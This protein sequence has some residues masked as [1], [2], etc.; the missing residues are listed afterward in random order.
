MEQL[1]DLRIQVQNDQEA[2]IG[3]Q[4][5]LGVIGFD[6]KDSMYLAANQIGE[7]TKSSNEATINRIVAE[8]KYRFLSDSDLNLIETQS[9]MLAS[10]KTSSTAQNSLLEG[11]RSSRAQ[12]ASVYAS[13]STQYGPNY[14]DVKQAKA[15][16]DGIDKEIDTEEKRVLSQARMSFVA[17][18][19]AEKS[20]TAAL[21]RQEGD[22]FKSTSDL[23][24]FAML[25]HDYEAHRTLYEGLV[26]RLREAGITSGLESGEVDVVDL[27]DLP[28][29]PSPP[30]P[31]TFIAG[32]IIIGF[33][34]G[35]L[36]ALVVDAL[37]TSINNAAQVEAILR[38]PLL[39]LLP[40]LD[41]VHL[42]ERTWDF[43]YAEAIQSLRSSVLLARA[44]SPPKVIMITSA[45]P[46]EG[47]SF[48]ARNLA[49][50][51]AQHDARILLIDCD[52]RRG[53]VAK[54]LGIS[55]I[56]GLSSLL[57]GQSTLE[58]AVQSVP[59]IPNLSV[60]TTGPHPPLPSVLIGSEAMNRLISKCREEY[61]FIILDSPPLLAITDTMNMVHLADVIVLVAR[62]NISHKQA[63]TEAHARLEIANADVLGFVLND[64]DPKWGGYN[65]VYHDYYGDETKAKGE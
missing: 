36:V 53:T 47:K 10:T 7:L 38:R 6:T 30:G 51:F 59:G 17:A 40:R 12:A 21:N 55:A 48:T 49:K 32:G 35:S 1:N 4:Q 43:R 11:L 58:R 25:S 39:G 54:S 5:R 56:A 50:A 64:V 29:I 16:L 34:V 19:A 37:E 26:G 23:A 31:I 9:P 14:P 63:I 3:L 13:L 20:T 42:A 24:K 65:Y 15:Q 62:Q 44:D 57:T 2:L 28:S 22:A 18:Q 41:A 61:D 52:M 45:L 8:T 46:A 60:V 27:A 33:I